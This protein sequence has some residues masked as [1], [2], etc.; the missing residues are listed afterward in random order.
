MVILP[1][2]KTEKM[3]IINVR[4]TLCRALVTLAVVSETC[5]AL[6]LNITAIATRRKAPV[7]ECW[8]MD[9]PFVVSTDAGIAG[10]ASVGLGNVT[11][12]T[13]TVLPAGFDGGLHNAPAKQ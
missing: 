10:S 8:E 6:R 3:Q 13:Y 12:L 11:Q 5:L 4:Q 7:L 1:H 9:T 2:H